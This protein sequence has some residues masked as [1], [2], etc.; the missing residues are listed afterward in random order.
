[1]HRKDITFEQAGKALTYIASMG[2]NAKRVDGAKLKLM[3][4]E[5]P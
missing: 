5:N 2:W 1:V 3:I 4:G